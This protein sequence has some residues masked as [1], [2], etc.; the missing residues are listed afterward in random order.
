ME[1]GARRNGGVKGC[2]FAHFLQRNDRWGCHCKQTHANAA[3]GL[4]TAACGLHHAS[5]SGHSAVTEHFLKVAS[6]PR[7]GVGGFRPL[8]KRIRAE[9]T[10]TMTSDQVVNRQRVK[11]LVEKP[12]NGTCAD[13]GAAGGSGGNRTVSVNAS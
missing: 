11:R 12:G 7:A 2:I 6:A 8:R 13:C 1:T 10:A 3:S 9:T 5:L 4:L